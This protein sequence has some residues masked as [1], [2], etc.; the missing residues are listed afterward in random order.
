MQCIRYFV[1]LTIS[2]KGS[3]LQVPHLYAAT[4]NFSVPTSTEIQNVICPQ[5]NLKEISW[6]KYMLF[7]ENY[8]ED[9]KDLMVRDMTVVEDFLSEEEEK[10]LHCEVE[11]YMKRLRYEFDHWDDAIHGYRE[12]ERLHWNTQNTLILQRVRDIAFPPGTPQLSL[13]HVLDLAE[14]GLIKPHIDSVRFCGN[15]I[16]GLSL[17]SDSVMRLV[18]EKHKERV[19]DILLKRRSLYI[20]KNTARYEF[21]H[22]ILGAENSKFGAQIVPRGRRIS[23]ICRNE[24]E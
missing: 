19:V 17:L 10:S 20:M 8:D 14:K 21:T 24:P 18:H 22:E 15:T 9:T 4:V 13:V 23:V 16:A 3:F 7:G 11:P 2:N 5:E 12:T 1:R 6:K